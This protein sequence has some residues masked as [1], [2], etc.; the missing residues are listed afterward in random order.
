MHSVVWIETRTPPRLARVCSG[1]VG[2]LGRLGHASTPQE[3]D[4]GLVRMARSA[5]EK[6]PALPSS[7]SPCTCPMSVQTV[8]HLHPDQCKCPVD[9]GAVQP[10]RPPHAAHAR[11][12][13]VVSVCLNAS[14]PFLPT[15]PAPSAGRGGTPYSHSEHGTGTGHAMQGGQTPTSTHKHCP[16]APDLHGAA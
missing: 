4:P 16:Q 15:A 10:L 2:P 5:L 9:C 1:N 3:P 8:F 11:C 6:Q 13:S 7:S 12:T 14:C